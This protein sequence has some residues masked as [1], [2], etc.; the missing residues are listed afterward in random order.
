MASVKSYKKINEKIMILLAKQYLPG[1]DFSM[2]QS[3]KD[4]VQSVLRWLRE[5]DTKIERIIKESTG[6]F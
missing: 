3:E 1:R 2:E 4:I 6:E 5:N